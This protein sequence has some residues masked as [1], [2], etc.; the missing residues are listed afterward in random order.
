MR[1]ARPGARRAVSLCAGVAFAILLALASAHPSFAHAKPTTSS[2][3]PNQ[4]LT[5]APSTVTIEFGQNVK[6]DGSDIII[7]DK[8]GQKVSTGPATVDTGD[9][10]KMTVPMKG[11]DSEA[12]LVVWHTV[13]ADDGEAAIGSYTF[14]VNAKADDLG[15][16]AS[17]DQS[18]SQEGITPLFAAL[19]GIL[20]L[21]LGAAGAYAFMRRQRVTA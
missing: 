3:S 8:N 12:Y 4:N 19:I 5:A 11:D 17:A 6:P 20:G 14:G 10:K 15:S 2:P 21:V 16:G 9:L 7:Y 13:S 18:G 1:L